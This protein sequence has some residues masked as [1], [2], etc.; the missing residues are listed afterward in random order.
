M[1]GWY[2]FLLLMV[3]IT[4][5][6]FFGLAVTPIFNRTK[7][8][9]ACAPLMYIILSAGTLIR[10]LAGDDAVASSESLTLLLTVLDAISSP[11]AFM[12][13]VHDI[14]SFDAVTAAQRPITWRT[15]EAPCSLM[16]MQSAGY[17]LLG[18]YLENVFPRTYGVQQKWYF[19][20]QSSYWFPKKMDLDNSNDESVRLT[21]MDPNN[22]DERMDDTLREQTI[23]DYLHHFNPTLLCS[24]CRRRIRTARRR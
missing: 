14:L 13:C 24:R 22:F 8:A 15:V 6:L 3:F 16:A 4:S 9:A 1:G 12:A 20:L 18:W 7:T 21:E 19:I 17:L 10:S 5:M 11:V 23:P 2:F